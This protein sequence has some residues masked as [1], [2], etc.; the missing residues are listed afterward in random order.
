MDQTKY[1]DTLLE[2]YGM[3]SCNVAHTPMTTSAPLHLDE[4][5]A[6]SE[7]NHALYRSIV[8]SLMYIATCTRPDISFAV[9]EL[10]R[11][12][13]QPTQAHLTAA[14]RRVLRYLKG[15]RNLQV[16][17]V[18]RLKNDMEPKLIGYAE[19]D[20]ARDVESRRSVSGKVFI[21]GSSPVAWKSK[22]Q[23]ITATS[24]TEA[25]NIALSEC[26]KMSMTLGNITHELTDKDPFP[27]NIYEDNRT[28]KMIANDE[29]SAKRTKHIDIKYHHIKNLIRLKKIHITD[30]S[31]EEQLADIFTK[32]L[33][34][35][36]HMHLTSKLVTFERE[37]K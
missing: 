10:G 14:K 28:A 3:V 11:F 8:G 13:H 36:G 15:T 27:I 7:S 33:P 34:K 2:Q 20:F 18:S 22:R 21:Y 4:N 26:S 29:S 12:T 19:A 24:T 25:E 31:S 32:P 1:I 6:L 23:T 37:Q 35:E 9:G 5:H 16:N 17:Y 30:I